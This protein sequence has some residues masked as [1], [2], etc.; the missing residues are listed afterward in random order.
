MMQCHRHI[1]F[2]ASQIEKTIVL[3]MLNPPAARSDS[4]FSQR[5]LMSEEFAQDVTTFIL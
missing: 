4:F 2:V 3:F 1:E 5:P